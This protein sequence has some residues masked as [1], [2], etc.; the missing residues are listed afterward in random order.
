[1]GARVRA[2]F[3]EKRRGTIHDIECFTQM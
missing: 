1:V 3:K 2:V